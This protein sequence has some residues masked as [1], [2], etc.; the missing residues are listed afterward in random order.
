MGVDLECRPGCASV[1][2]GIMSWSSPGFTAPYYDWYIVHQ[3]GAHPINHI[4]L[5][6][7]PIMY[8][9][10]TTLENP[11]QLS[12]NQHMIWTPMIFHNHHNVSL[13]SQT[14]FHHSKIMANCPKIA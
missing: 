4:K 11:L 13:I 9:P 12:I 10:V 3:C 1:Q 2:V 5:V 6:I 7:R 14:V 8:I